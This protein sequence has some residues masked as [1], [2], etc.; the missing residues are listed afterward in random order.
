MNFGL[1]ATRA[2]SRV[3]TTPLMRQSIHMRNNLFYQNKRDIS[4]R[5]LSTHQDCFNVVQSRDPQQPEFLQAVQEVI[6]SC[7]PL[8][9]KN[10]D[11]I[12]VLPVICE[13]ERIIQFRVPWVDDQGHTHVNRGFRVQFS[14]ALGP[15]KGG[16]RFHPS[17]NQSIIKFLGFEQIFKNALTGLPLGGAKGGSDFNP[18]EKSDAEV[19]RFCQAFMSELYAHI[20]PDTDVPAGDIGV[21][22]RE[23]GFL[24]GQ[25]KQITA[26]CQGVLTGK[27]RLWGGSHIR[28]EATGYGVVYITQMALKDHGE[29]FEG[30]RVAVSGSGN[31]AEFTCEKAME[32]GATIVSFSDSGGSIVEPDGF[33]E[34][35]FALLRDIKRQRGRVSEYAKLSKTCQFFQGERPW[36]HVKC[37]IALPSA[38]Q[39]EI[40]A[41]DALA[42][43][44]N[45]CYCVAEGANM[46]TT[47]DAIE[48][49]QKNCK[50][51]VPAKASNAGGVAVSGLEMAQNSARVYW[52]REEV[53]AYLQRI[54]ADIYHDI[55]ETSAHLGYPGD[56]MLGANAVGYKR[57][58]DAM[59]EQGAPLK[60]WDSVEEPIENIVT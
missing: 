42:L 4:V 60:S 28:P 30:K 36:K 56:F 50:V 29:S 16:L 59:F 11:Y 43:V 10:R 33:T 1:R 22:A 23:I 47:P 6:E 51:Y 35:Q 13:P 25:W 2:V 18:K 49:L 19:L 12:R 32:L 39:N 17:V 14:Q 54:M 8:F 5:V 55:K 21:G 38:T 46:P 41:E 44:E 3:N 15:Y 57:V 24:Y 34:Q 7:Q 26:K 52:T 48:I 40:D 58:A 45:G 37:D 20:G 9:K 27:G 31:V 53:D